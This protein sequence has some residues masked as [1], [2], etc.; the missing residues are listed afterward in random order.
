MVVLV[1]CF[2]EEC[3]VEVEEREDGNE[4]GSEMVI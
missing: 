2:C 1:V 4:V 3:A